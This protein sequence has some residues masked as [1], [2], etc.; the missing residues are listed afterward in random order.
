M[1]RSV[2]LADPADHER[3]ANRL[4]EVDGDGDRAADPNQGRGPAERFRVGSPERL[5][6]RIVDPTRHRWRRAQHFDT[7][8]DAGRR[9]RVDLLLDRA[10]ITAGS[11]SG[12]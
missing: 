5:R 7:D 9:Q 4:L 12:T 2:E 1:R 6:H 8:L 3:R 10:R 11:W